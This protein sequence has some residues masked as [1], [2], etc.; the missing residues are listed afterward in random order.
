MKFANKRQRRKAF[1]RWD[2]IYNLHTLILEGVLRLNKKYYV[3]QH[4]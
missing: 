4:K 1:N 2:K 3:G